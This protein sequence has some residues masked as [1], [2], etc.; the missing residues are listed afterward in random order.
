MLD[1]QHSR[2]Y[3]THPAYIWEPGLFSRPTVSLPTPTESMSSLAGA[4]EG[5]ARGLGLDELA[6]LR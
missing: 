4:P 2:E 5:V 3:W 1:K 6:G